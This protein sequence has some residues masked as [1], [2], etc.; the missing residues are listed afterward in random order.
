MLL[1]TKN[2]HLL[3][4]ANSSQPKPIVA[5]A[6]A[7]AC[8]PNATLRGSPHGEPL[9]R[10][11][12]ASSLASTP[13][14]FPCWC[15]WGPTPALVLAASRRR[16]PPSPPAHNRVRPSHV[17]LLPR[18]DGQAPAHRDEWWRLGDAIPIA[19][20]GDRF[21]TPPPH[22]LLAVW[23][24]LF[25]FLS[26]GLDAVRPSDWP[27]LSAVG[28]RWCRP[29]FPVRRRREPRRRTRPVK[30]PRRRTLGFSAIHWLAGS[31]SDICDLYVYV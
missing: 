18:A 7:V 25:F 15:G 21:A 26:C 28:R 17:T 10:W 13:T 3:A 31:V 29:L 6:V 5:Y 20:R 16:P 4:S 8:T 30:T 14:T 11:H 19:C 1:I 23:L 12:A 27:R 2:G 24:G 9:S 22:R